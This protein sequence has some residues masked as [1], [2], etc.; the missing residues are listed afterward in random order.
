[1]ST[2]FT[3]GRI[4]TMDPASAHASVV[5]VHG[6]RIVEVGGHELLSAHP[7]ADVIDLGASVLVPGF[8]DAHN[9][10]S[11]AALHPR[12]RDVKGVHDRQVLRDAI[13]AQDA[14]EPET[15]WI[16]LQGIDAFAFPVTRH[17]LD[18]AGVD[19]PVIVADYT[20]H[21]CVVSS[22]ALEALG[23]GRT[24]DDPPGGEI[25]R[26][27]H[28]D[29][30]GFLIERAWSE[31]HA[32]SMRDYAD[33]DQ[34]PLHIAARAREL[35]ADGITCVHDAACSGAA[36]TV[37][38]AMAREGTLPI[39]VVGLPHPAELLMNDVGSRLDGA[40]TGEGDERFRVGPAKL[41]ADG[42]AAIALDTTVGGHPVQMG[43]LFDDLGEHA[44]RAVDRG[45][46][47]AIHAMGNRGVQAMIDVC[48][49][50]GRRHPDHDHRF[51]VEH[52]GVTSADQW[53]RLAALGAIAVVQPGFVEHVGTQ[54]GGMRFDDH[55]WLAFAGLAEAGVTLAGSSDDPCAPPPPLW[56]AAH[57][58][59]RR[60]SGGIDFEPEQ[61]V[62]FEDWLAAY[63][64]GAA[65]AGGQ[66]HERGTIT[67]GKRADLVFLDR[68]DLGARVL[69]TWI[70]GEL[71]SQAGGRGA[72]S[73]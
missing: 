31:A 7:G 46:R 20:L 3:G 54:A 62:P 29:P 33:P 60:T 30:T 50:L 69:E 35:V 66:E 6:D 58:L 25:A 71:V 44:Q 61:A 47:I 8:I 1:M 12:W 57:G 40:P 13:R 36:E 17:D 39:S 48:A 63:T 55:H 26:D 52:A 22:A 68:A 51:R 37:Y 64:R 10:L 65:L 9:H 16:R 4:L 49:D 19:R 27:Q 23:I 11:V 42:G 15:A 32:Q 67:P 41:F 5:V 53:R 28:G 73:P 70:G 2:A 56:C 34:W 24:T 21:Q 43:M 45:F 14:A 59:T 38:R 72:S 18:A